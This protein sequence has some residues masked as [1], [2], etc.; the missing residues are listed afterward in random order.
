MYI[1]TLR[2]PLL[3]LPLHAKRLDRTSQARRP[4][5]TVAVPLPWSTMIRGATGAHMSCTLPKLLPVSY[6]DSVFSR[7]LHSRSAPNFI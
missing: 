5:G 2:A 1:C 3:P 4:Q 7:S 6:S